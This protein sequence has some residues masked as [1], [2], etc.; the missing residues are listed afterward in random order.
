MSLYYNIPKPYVVTQAVKSVTCG[1]NHFGYLTQNNDLYM[2][3]ENKHGQLSLNGTYISK[4]TFVQSG[5]EKIICDQN[6]S[7][8]IDI[9]HQVFMC[10]ENGKNL[11]NKTFTF[12]TNES[13][14]AMLVVQ[15][16]FGIP[17]QYAVIRLDST[18]DIT[19]PDEIFVN[20]YGETW[21]TV[22]QK[23]RSLCQRGNYIRYNKMN[24]DWVEIEWDQDF[25]VQLAGRQCYRCR[26]K[27]LFKS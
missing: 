20:Q 4:P 14:D 27:F 24:N 3:G 9:D 1:A 19:S 15:P 25:D 11:T 13:R 6:W 16:N 21:L 10:G 26:W 2:W 17:T 7:V 8:Y 12:L 23:V 18:L 5:V 22:D